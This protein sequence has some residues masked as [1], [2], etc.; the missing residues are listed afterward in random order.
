MHHYLCINA[1]KSDAAYNDLFTLFNR[2]TLQLA[3]YYLYL[4]IVTGVLHQPDEDLGVV[5]WPVY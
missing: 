5:C 1:W 4:S 3:I 2:F